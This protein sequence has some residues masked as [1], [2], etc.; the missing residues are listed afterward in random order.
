MSLLTMSARN[1]TAV[2]ESFGGRFNPRGNLDTT[3]SKKYRIDFKPDCKKPPYH[4]TACD[5]NQAALMVVRRLDIGPR[6]TLV[7]FDAADAQQVY[8][9]TDNRRMFP[10]HEDEKPH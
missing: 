3:E 1:A 5:D 8:C 6:L 9:E 2:S 4:F 7:A 10:S